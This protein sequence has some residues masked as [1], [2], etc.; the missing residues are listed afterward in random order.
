VP[1]PN[2]GILLPLFN[3]TVSA[4]GI[5]IWVKE[6]EKAKKELKKLRM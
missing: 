6:T 5:F 2:K 4:K 1:K 3:V